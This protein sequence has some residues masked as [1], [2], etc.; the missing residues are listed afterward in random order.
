MPVSAFG[1][2]ALLARP[3]ETTKA[4]EARNPIVCWEVTGDT[5]DYLRFS[6]VSSLNIARFVI[7]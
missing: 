3:D 4:A 2:A 1:E 7:K 5:D 6:R